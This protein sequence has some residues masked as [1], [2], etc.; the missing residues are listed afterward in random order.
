MQISYSIFICLPVEHSEAV[1][2][3]KEHLSRADPT[4]EDES[5]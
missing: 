3:F 1:S 5:E 2:E 4:I